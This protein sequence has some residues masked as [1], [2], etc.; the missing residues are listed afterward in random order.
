MAQPPGGWGSQPPSNENYS[1]CSPSRRMPCEPSNEGA[2][3]EYLAAFALAGGHQFVTTDK[4]F[5][6]FKGLDLLLLSEA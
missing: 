1:A 3:C 4:A 6:Q 2:E 5:R